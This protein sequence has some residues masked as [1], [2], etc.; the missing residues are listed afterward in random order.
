MYDPVRQHHIKIQ[1][2]HGNILC[3]GLSKY[4]NVYN[5]N[6]ISINSYSL[7]KPTS[8]SIGIVHHNKQQYFVVDIKLHLPQFFRN[9]L[10]STQWFH[11]SIIVPLRP[12]YS[13]YRT[14]CQLL[15][16]CRI[17][18]TSILQYNNPFSRGQTLILNL[19]FTFLINKLNLFGL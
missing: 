4:A 5:L 10:S 7:N 8:I 15:I 3:M 9:I 18:S 17:G 14:I 19:F 2:F 16:F 6:K 11:H 12:L 13:Q 1:A